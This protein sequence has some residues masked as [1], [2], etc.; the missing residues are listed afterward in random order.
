MEA[1]AHQA[2]RLWGFAPGQITLAA[3]RE[4]VV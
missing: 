3:R 4:N 1:L 2:A